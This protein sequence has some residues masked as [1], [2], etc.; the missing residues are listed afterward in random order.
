LVVPVAAVEGVGAVALPVP[1]EAWV[2][3]KRSKVLGLA[4]AVSGV[5]ASPMQ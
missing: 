1:P 5:A 3:H 4:V 2:Y